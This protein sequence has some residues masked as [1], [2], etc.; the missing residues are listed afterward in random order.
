VAG[1]PLPASIM[2]TELK[3]IDGKAIKLSDYAG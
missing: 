1:T 3:T 2:T